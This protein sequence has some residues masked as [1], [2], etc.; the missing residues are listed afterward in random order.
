MPLI[1]CV[2]TGSTRDTTSAYGSVS[3]PSS[4][5]FSSSTPKPIS[6]SVSRQAAPLLVGEVH[7]VI[8]LARQFVDV[9]VLR[10]RLEQ[11]AIAHALEI[12]RRR[13]QQL[14]VVIPLRLEIAAALVRVAGEGLHGL[15]GGL[16]Q[17]AR[18][19]G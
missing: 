10:Q 18:L 7:P 17:P 9:A 2:S 14:Q 6:T 5:M 12:G 16:L 3:S 8:D 15:R 13:I 11:A 4:L 1:E 19:G